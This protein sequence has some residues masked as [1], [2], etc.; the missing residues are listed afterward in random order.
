MWKPPITLMVWAALMGNSPPPMK[1]THHWRLQPRWQVEIWSFLQGTQAGVQHAACHVKTSN[2]VDGLGSIDGQQCNTHEAHSSVESATTLASAKMV[3][4]S[5]NT[6]GS[7]MRPVTWKPPIT[8]MAAMT[9]PV[10]RAWAASGTP[11]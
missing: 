2:H 7:S 1:H 10:A 11:P 5:R 4:P 8:L 9:L 3:I 6:G